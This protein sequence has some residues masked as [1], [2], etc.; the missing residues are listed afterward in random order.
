M[1]SCRCW[2]VPGVELPGK[3]A[4][5]I[6]RSNIVGKPLANLLMRKS[7]QANATVTV[8]HTATPDVPVHPAGGRRHCRRRP[9]NTLTADMVRD[10]AV[11]IDVG[12][13]RILDA[14]KSGYRLVGDVDFEPV[15]RKAGLIT[16]VPGGVGP[17]TILM[18]LANTVQ[19]ANNT[20]G[21]NTAGA[22]MVCARPRQGYEPSSAASGSCLRRAEAEM[23]MPAP[24]AGSVRIPRTWRPLRQPKSCNR[25]EWESGPEHER[26]AIP[27]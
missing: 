25:L 8:C 6:G 7:P 3:H 27:F 9:A 19:A 15:S 12:V 24:A 14:A 20:A 21:N 22:V 17:M 2:R 10:G 18:L 1:Q 11:V 26:P 4:V 13:G 16:P 23:M 5:V